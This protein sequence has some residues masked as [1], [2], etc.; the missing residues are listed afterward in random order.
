MDAAD[1]CWRWTSRVVDSDGDGADFAQLWSH[2][3]R[4]DVV[5]FPSMYGLSDCLCW[6]NRLLSS[7]AKVADVRV[8]HAQQGR[9]SLWLQAESVKSFSNVLLMHKHSWGCSPLVVVNVFSLG[10]RLEEQMQFSQ[11]F[12][13]TSSK[14]IT[15]CQHYFNIKKGTSFNTHKMNELKRK[16]TIV[17]LENILKK[18]KMYFILKK[19]YTHSS[20]ETRSLVQI[21]LC[22]ERKIDNIIITY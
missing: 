12:C 21:Y 10:R 7:F 20:S 22:Q 15:C 16:C 14:I 19:K 1:S 6:S 9:S 18:Q 8:I 3:Q 2:S 17:L 5:S 11:D 13:I 4:V